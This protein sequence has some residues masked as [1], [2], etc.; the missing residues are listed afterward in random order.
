VELV[1]SDRKGFLCATAGKQIILFG[2]GGMADEALSDLQIERQVTCIIDNDRLLHGK[3]K[4]YGTYGYPIKPVEYLSGLDLTDNVILITSQY[5]IEIFEQLKKLDFLDNIVCYVYHIMRYEGQDLTEISVQHLK[6]ALHLCGYDKEHIEKT[7]KEK[8]LLWRSPNAYNDMPFV[9]PKI[10]FCITSKCTLRCEHCCVRIPYI[11][12]PKHIPFEQLKKEVDTIL[13]AVDEVVTLSFIGGEPF[14]YPWL[15]EILEYT[16]QNP[17]VTVIPLFTNCTILP[18]EKL[19][20]VLQHPKILLQLSDYGHI[21]KMALLIELLEKHSIRFKVLTDEK[22]RDS[23]GIE[24]RKRNK[25]EL[26]RIYKSC[27]CSWR[28]C[29]VSDGRL[30]ACPI[31]PWLAMAGIFSSPHDYE[32]ILDCTKE[33]V[34]QMMVKMFQIDYAEACNY[35]D[36]QNPYSKSFRPGIQINGSFQT[37]RYTLINRKQYKE[38]LEMV[39]EF[40]YLEYSN[41]QNPED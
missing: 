36:G 41:E 5:H 1:I 29:Y 16:A 11:K 14:I 33:E 9:L 12:E 31:A 3:T 6:N 21:V 30:W 24:S 19:L 37:S 8:S 27:L 2:A 39:K 10:T 17:K 4:R 13:N 40:Q 38:L 15:A 35:C 23:G 22:W 32:D 20:N 25:E 18:D 26:R 7:V 28:V 34:R